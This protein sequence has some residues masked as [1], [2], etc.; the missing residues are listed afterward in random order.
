MA[1]QEREVHK[2]LRFKKGDALS[3]KTIRNRRPVR[4]R[5]LKTIAEC[6]EIF[7]SQV[8]PESEDRP[9]VLRRAKMVFY[10]GAAF[11]MDQ[12]IAVGEDG[13]T[14]DQGVAHMEALSRE[15]N[16]FAA[17]LALDVAETIGLA[18]NGRKH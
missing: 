2:T 18:P 9:D 17:E 4:P 16:L 7:S 13:V 5:E 15:L 3:F 10:A 6:W 11:L 14:E 12:N 1:D 8:I